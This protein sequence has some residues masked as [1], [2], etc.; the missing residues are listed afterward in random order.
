MTDERTN[1]PDG[2][3]KYI[4]ATTGEDLGKPDKAKQFWN[5][6]QSSIGEKLR[7]VYAGG[8]TKYL[9]EHPEQFDE[10]M[11]H[12]EAFITSVIAKIEDVLSRSDREI[13]VLFDLDETLVSPKRDQQEKL[14][15]IVRPSAEPLFN[16]YLNTL[17]ESQRVKAGFLST[18]GKEAMVSQLSDPD[19]LLQL[20]RFIDTSLVYSTEDLEEV[21]E[22]GNT[23]EIIARKHSSKGS[24]LLQD[25][26]VQEQSPDHYMYSD[27]DWYKLDCLQ[28][29][30]K[31][32]PD[33]NIIVVDD[34]LFPKNLNESQGVYGVSLQNK[35]KFYARGH[36]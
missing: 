8:S 22:H 2:A 10:C 21:Y 12:E 29:I 15:S 35:G 33:S 17:I 16:D 24:G 32:H 25:D 30:K 4:A 31:S 19:N 11:A 26:S 7:A 20:A 9:D 14:I 28:H 27:G 34:L 1:T 18:R 6:H 36:P 23:W 3:E 5:Q 13:I